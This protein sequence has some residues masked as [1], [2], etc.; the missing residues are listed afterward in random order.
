MRI[1]SVLILF[2][3]IFYSCSDSKE[4]KIASHTFEI[5]D[6][7][8]CTNY[9]SGK[10]I[11]PIEID[12]LNA[13]DSGFV[14]PS[15]NQTSD[16]Y[17]TF[18]FS[19]KNNSDKENEYFYKIYYQNE[20]YKFPEFIKTKT[21]KDPNPMAQENFYGS[22]EETD[23]DFKP[24]GT[25]KNDGKFHKIEDKIRIV[26]NPRD[27]KRYF[28][29]I[30]KE[31]TDEDLNKI[32]NQIKNSPE[33]LDN[34]K[35]KAKNNK[36]SVESQIKTDA[37]FIFREE[38]NDFTINERW[39]RNPRVGEYSFMLVVIDKK[40]YLR[41]T[42]PI[43]IEN[44]AEQY[45]GMFVNPYY[46]FLYGDGKNI[47]NAITVLSNNRI[48]VFAKPD[49]ASGIYVDPDMTVGSEYNKSYFNE[50]CGNNE[51][52]YK[53]SHFQQFF[54][55]LK[56]ID[57]ISNIPVTEDIFVSDYTLNMYE[58]NSKK[59]SEKERVNTHIYNTN[60]PCKTVKS[61]KENKKITLF[62][63]ASDQGKNIKENV[64]IKS[65]HGFTYGKFRIKAKIKVKYSKSIKICTGKGST[66][67]TSCYATYYRR[68]M[69]VNTG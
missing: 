52:I 65:R 37:V 12:Y 40:N 62:N 3:I 8:A 4:E 1:T 53:S 41:R 42:I 29:S 50:N 16:G 21:G 34:I 20:S 5:K 51:Q 66:I 54:H 68:N 67:T 45:S 19:L 32:I 61:D 57:K 24:T 15:I 31:P 64:G 36:I 38:K 47:P 35:Q 22:W 10:Q 9:L 28:G 33:W 43:Y 11:K 6:F 13:I 56:D 59:F 44:I 63:P 27:E 48:K 55:L 69:A 23:I 49:L 46:Y 7:N 14:I 17:F 2:L 25:I 30:K 18:E 26:G 60:C 39:K 58:E